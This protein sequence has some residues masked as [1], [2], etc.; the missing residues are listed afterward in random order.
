MARE[1]LKLVVFAIET[2]DVIYEYGIPIGQVYE[3]TRPSSTIKLPGAPAFVEGI[4][5]LRGS[6]IPVIDIKKRFELGSIAVKD[7]TRVVIIQTNGHKC[8]IIVDDVLEIMLISGENI[9]EIPA[10]AGGISSQYIIGVGKVENR[11]IIAL[12]MNT[13][14]TEYENNQLVQ[15]EAQ[16]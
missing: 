12:D 9:D 14:L 4:M 6:I 10:V 1:T 15:I 2:D 7:S 13:I 5:N 8:G 11:M 16:N 3:I